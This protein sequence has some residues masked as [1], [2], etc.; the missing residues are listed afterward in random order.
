[1]RT[2]NCGSVDCAIVC[3]APCYAY[4]FNQCNF[5]WVWIYREEVLLV[6][7]MASEAAVVPAPGLEQIDYV[8]C[9]QGYPVYPMTALNVFY[10]NACGPLA[11]EES[12][13]GSIKA[14]FR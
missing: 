5:D 9:E 10:F 3:I 12:T 2:V 1:M 13:W 11:I 6:S 4:S 14:L 8:S 7:S